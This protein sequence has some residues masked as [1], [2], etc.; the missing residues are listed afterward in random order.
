MDNVII[1]IDTTLENNIVSIEEN[2][3]NL[4][5]EASNLENGVNIDVIEDV[6]NTTIEVSESVI[7]SVLIEVDKAPY[8]RYFTE[9]L[10]IAYNGVVNWITTNGSNLINHLSNTSNPHSVTKTHIGLSNVD[11][12]SDLDKPVSTIVLSSL[13]N[14]VD[15]LEFS[16]L[17]STSF[18]IHKAKSLIKQQTQ[19]INSLNNTWI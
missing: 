19:F 12:T 16:T 17:R 2:V 7:E 11:N 1:N 6:T 18:M 4:V 15:N 14:K 8:I 5:I 9:S 13:D 3:T 10:Q